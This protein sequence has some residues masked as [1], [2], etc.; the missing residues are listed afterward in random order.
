MFLHHDVEFIIRLVQKQK[1]PNDFA[2][3]LNFVCA[4]F[5]HSFNILILYYLLTLLYYHDIHHISLLYKH[6]L[7]LRCVFVVNVNA[8]FLRREHKICSKYTTF[9]QQLLPFFLFLFFFFY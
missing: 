4:P 1:G 6:Y 9:I 2:T 5:V 3:D 8:N 7:V